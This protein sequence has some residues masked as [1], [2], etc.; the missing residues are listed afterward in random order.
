MNKKM[1]EFARKEILTGL[2][3]L[4]ENNILF[5]KR[6]YSHKNLDLNINDV[7]KN[8]PDDKLEHALFQIDNTLDNLNLNKENKLYTWAKKKL[9]VIGDQ[10]LLNL[11][12]NILSISRLNPTLRIT[13]LIPINDAQLAVTKPSTETA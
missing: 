2:K 6:M 13:Y 11:Q 8:M 1:S 10:I 3:K 4:P 9:I 12:L 7:V 5:F